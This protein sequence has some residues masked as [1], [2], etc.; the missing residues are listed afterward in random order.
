MDVP[1]VPTDTAPAPSIERVAKTTPVAPAPRD[2]MAASVEEEAAD[3]SIAAIAALDPPSAL[4]VEDIEQ[5]PV[6]VPA[7]AMSRLE[8]GELTVEPLPPPAEGGKE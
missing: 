7:L 6:N 2:V 5:P 8:I 1:P 4:A 3:R